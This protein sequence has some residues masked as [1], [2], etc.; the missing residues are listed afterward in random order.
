VIT[1]ID[2]NVRLDIISGEQPQGP[3]PAL[4]SS[5]FLTPDRGIYTDLDFIVPSAGDR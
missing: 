1:A 3:V 5:R 2:T 4:W